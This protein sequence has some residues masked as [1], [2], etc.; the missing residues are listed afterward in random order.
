LYSFVA[1][2]GKVFLVQKTD[3]VDFGHL[4]A[5]KEL[6]KAEITK[7]TKITK[8]TNTERQVLEAVRQSPFLIGLQYAFQTDETLHLILGEHK[9]C[10]I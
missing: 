3:G 4:Y 8:Y 1:A 2:F 7:Y 10:N 5:I 9:H 6:Q